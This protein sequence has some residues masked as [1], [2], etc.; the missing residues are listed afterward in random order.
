MKEERMQPPGPLSDL[1]KADQ[2]FDWLMDCFYEVLLEA[3]NADLAEILPFRGS[4]PESV[5]RISSSRHIQAYAIAFQL[6]NQVE[7]N[8]S[9]QTRRQAEEC[10]GPEYERG[11]WGQVLQQLRLQ[12]VAEGAIAH[13][14]P[15]IRVEPVL[16][17]H[18]T[19]A[20]RATVL[21]HYR[22]LYLLLVRRENQIWTA[23]ERQEIRNQV[24]ATLEL[25]WRT[26]DIF[27]EKPDVASELNNVIYYLRRVFPDVLVQ[28]D[29]RLRQVWTGLGSDPSLL[30][31]ATSLPRLTFSTW[32]GG[33]RDGHPLVTD[34]V[35]RSALSEL[36]HNAL[37]LL[38]Q[39]LGQLGQ[40]LSLSDH[41]QA[42]PPALLAYLGK[43]SQTGG[44]E[45]GGALLRNPNE[46]WRQLVNVMLVRLP[47]D[48][49]G[50]ESQAYQRSDQLAEDLGRLRVALEEV[51]AARLADSEV[52]KVERAVQCFGFHLA[53]L[54]IRQNSAFH[55]RAVDQLLAAAGFA[56]H[57]FSAWDEARRRAFVEQELESPRPF[58]RPDMK[59]G[60]EATAVLACYRVVL[61]HLRRYG[62]AGLGGLI[63]S[64]TRSVV[65]LLVVYLLAR[66]VG[67]LCEGE[68]GPVCSLGVVPLFETIEDLEGSGRILEE[69][70]RHPITLR[71]LRTQATGEPTQ[72]VMVGYSDSNKD[73]GMLASL[74][75]LYRAEGEL[76]AVGRAHGVRIRFFHGRGGTISRGS[77]PAGRFIR[78]LPKA[79]LGGD[80]RLTEQGETIAQKYANRISAVYNL[81]LLLA[82]VT[83]VT[84]AKAS[85][86][87]TPHPLEPTMDRLA[88]WSRD[89]YVQLVSAEGFLS[90]FGEAT[91]IDVIE[92]SRIG[93]R[94]SRRSGR[95][96]L[97]D[98]RAIPWVFSWSQARFYLSGW[99][100][101]G[102]AL[103][104]LL[105][106]DPASFED[107]GEQ[108]MEWASLHYIVSNAATSIMTA[109]PAIMTLYAGLVHEESVRVS[110][111]GRILEEY[112]RTR[113]M[114]E[115]VYG[116]PLQLKRPH[117]ARLLAKRERALNHLHQ[118]QVHLLRQWRSLGALSSEAEQVLKR[119]LLTV[120]AIAAGLRTTG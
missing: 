18:P 103:E 92:Q 64:M 79:A 85:Q 105:Q 49:S 74:W 100:G 112:E 81:E 67:L 35:T 82:G 75:G 65:D 43:I 117:P 40:R 38:R 17:A 57:Q 63:V 23:H 9:A 95:H 107:L 8:A 50:L 11:L 20:K 76:A 58:T 104:K 98:L 68:Q 31:S 53:S 21:E 78:A 106:E 39:L 24:K 42:P 15:S 33:D 93:S 87:L 28:L 30:R 115:Q 102:S 60:P 4:A 34:G 69:F 32:V 10:F 3:G 70:F 72:Q 27:L 83:G 96:S 7:E 37:G 111:L 19:E 90:F 22:E 54:D 71:S 120:N 29:S 108:L 25:L 46:P 88:R 59:L 45:V 118:R 13:A 86:A 12:G 116:G 16:T 97:S 51:G 84:L 80:L 26:G 5:S 41:L 6:L 66:E 2:D 36:R 91:P 113:R 101:V 14:L 62:P 109:D 114:L 47:G 77:G 44:A 89:A 119:L 48:G 99:Y 1:D 52:L 94:P 61:D 55:D 110:V 73:G 56:D